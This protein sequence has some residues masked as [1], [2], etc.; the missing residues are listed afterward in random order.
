MDNQDL[1]NVLA[2]AA[3]FIPFM[4]PPG[5]RARV[6]F[7]PEQKSSSTLD[8]ALTQYK[9]TLIDVIDGLNQALSDID[10]L[11]AKIV[12]LQESA[13]HLI[14]IEKGFA[15]CLET[16][17]K[18]EDAKNVDT[19]KNDLIQMLDSAKV[20]DKSEN[21]ENFVKSL[22][23]FHQEWYAMM[24]STIKMDQ[25]KGDCVICLDEQTQLVLLPECKHTLCFHCM[26]KQFWNSSSNLFKSEAQCPFCRQPFHIQDVYAN[27]VSKHKRQKVCEEKKG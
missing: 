14:R 17:F 9:H 21:L 5:R 18:E 10:G 11:S 25:I 1:G 7:A 23:E 24:D 26:I 8:T 20:L 12:E 3:F 2:H 16:T 13:A 22:D 6:R 19:M 27:C 4:Q 15:P